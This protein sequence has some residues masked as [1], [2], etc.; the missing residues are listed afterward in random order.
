VVLPAVRATID[1]IAATL[2]SLP[3]RWMAPLDAALVAL[4]AV[5]SAVLLVRLVLAWR[6]LAAVE[7][8][9]TTDVIAGVPVL[10]TPGL[11]PAV[12]GAHHPRLLVPR[13]LLDLDA[14]LRA[15]VLRHEAEHCRAR[16]P[17]LVLA[18]AIAV[19][20]VPW[21]VGAWWI[22]RRLRLA[23]ELD[24]DARVLR[25]DDDTERYGKLLLFIAQS[26]SQSQTRL[27]PMLAESNSHLSRRITT[28]TAPR[29]THPHVRVAFL[30][31]VGAGALAC[32]TKY[33]TDLAAP[34]TAQARARSGNAQGA[35]ATYYEPKGAKPARPAN[36]V[37]P[38]YPD[39]L[40]SARVEG[41]VLVAFVVDTSGLVVA[42][43]LKVLRST[44]PLFTQAVRDAVPSMRF[45]PADLN[46]RKVK[47]LVQ[48]PF[49]FD[50]RG[51]AASA[52]RKPAPRATPTSDPA[53]RNPMTLRPIV[54]TVP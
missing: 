48:E 14:P 37:V 52:A 28:M 4:W 12:F 43:T 38:R 24:C 5:A 18:A 9:A 49:Y 29:P 44:D 6:A 51:S 19:A 20:L 21:N 40:R 17:Q 23:V 53:N 7:R 13:W 1:D 26:Q 39:S 31:L 42:S 33:A 34:P 8:T 46:G 54:V 11:G 25:I 15:L 3:Q 35:S 41:E 22:A 2:P 30:A 10:V 50:V 47:Q 16:D 45:V 27:A 32:S 36:S